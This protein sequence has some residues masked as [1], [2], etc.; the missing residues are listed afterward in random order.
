MTGPLAQALDRLASTEV[1]LVALDFDGT[2]APFVENPA[3]ARAVPE[4]TAAVA[5][6]LALDRTHVAY[7]SGRALDS[8]EQATAAPETVLLVG[9]HGAE[10]RLGAGESH[11]PLTESDLIRVRRLGTVLAGVASRHPGARIEAKPAGL[12]LHT[13]TMDAREALV[14]A[15]DARRAV[16]EEDPDATVRDGKDVV[17]FSV[18]A[19]TKGDGIRRLRAFTGA[20]AVLYAGDDVTDEDAFAVLEPGDMALKAGEGETIATHR[21]TGPLEVAAVLERLAAR[22][23]LAAAADS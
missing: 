21:A 19:A 15:E 5:R 13:R 16:A 22:R 14:T 3:D 9:S 1:L 6:L 23:G 7:V 2:L 4:A 11:A 8:L 18:L 20:T 12:A 10:Y 17:E